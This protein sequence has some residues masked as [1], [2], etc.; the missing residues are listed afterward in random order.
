MLVELCRKTGADGAINCMM[1][2]CDPEEYDQP[3]LEADLRRANI[4]VMKIE[5]DP[6][7]ASFEQLRTKIQSFSELLA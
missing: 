5:I 1:K 3:Y 4:P 7:D 6:L 2:F